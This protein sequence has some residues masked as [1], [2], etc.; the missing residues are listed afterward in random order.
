MSN[1]SREAVRPKCVSQSGDR[2]IELVGDMGGEKKQ[3]R[4]WQ[5]EYVK[6]KLKREPK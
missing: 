1:L 4:F 6:V 5:K 2:Q 3:G